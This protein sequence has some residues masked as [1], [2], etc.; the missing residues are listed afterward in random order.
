MIYITLFYEFF[1]IGLFAIGGGMAS[2]P[3]L[4]DLAENYNWFTVDEL[5]NMVAISQS[6]PGP[7]G[8]NMA[9]Y[10]GYEAAGILGSLIATFG[11]VLPSFIVIMIIAKFM[12]NFNKLPVVQ[13][14][15][16]GIRPVVVGLIFCAILE[17]CKLSLLNYSETTGY[18]ANYVSIGACVLLFLLMFPKKFKKIHPICWIAAGAVLGIVFKL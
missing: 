8:I 4:V 3:F 16:S 12:Q 13:A 6:T 2:I 10:A 7:I 9:T 1:Q 18:S 11:L 5:T 14:A 17:L 15:F